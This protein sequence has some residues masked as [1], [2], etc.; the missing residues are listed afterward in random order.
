MT[1]RTL[2]VW[3]LLLLLCGLIVLATWLTIR[4][5]RPTS[6]GAALGVGGSGWP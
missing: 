1:P 4:W 3:C 6:G 2:A 5:I